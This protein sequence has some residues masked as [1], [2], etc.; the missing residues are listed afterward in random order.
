MTKPRT[1]TIILKNG[2]EVIINHDSKHKCEK[3]K[4]EIIWALIPIELVSL[5]QWDIHKCEYGNKKTTK[6]KN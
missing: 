1:Q 2:M 4:K 3:C 5:A 6:R